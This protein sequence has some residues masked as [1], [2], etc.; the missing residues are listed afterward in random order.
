MRQSTTRECSGDDVLG[1]SGGRRS[2]FRHGVRQVGKTKS[3]CFTVGHKRSFSPVI[4]PV[5][6]KDTSHTPSWVFLDFYRPTEAQL[7]PPMSGIYKSKLRLS[8]I[9][10]NRH[11]SV[12]QMNFMEQTI[13]SRHYLIQNSYVHIFICSKNFLHLKI[14]VLWG[15]TTC[16]V[17]E[18]NVSVGGKSCL[19]LMGRSQPSVQSQSFYG[20]RCLSHPVLTLNSFWGIMTIFWV[21]R[22]WNSSHGVSSLARKRTLP[23]LDILVLV[24][25]RCSQIYS[26]LIY[27]ALCMSAYSG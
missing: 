19:H 10:F 27:K 24:N 20:W 14:T 7:F 5:S 8:G 18:F 26:V 17:V 16:S 6:H 1:R 22:L 4:L 15:V 2:G 21:S 13:K 23:L 25:G 12:F 11:V 9:H 3:A